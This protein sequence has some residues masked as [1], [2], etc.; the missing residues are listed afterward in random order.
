M[1]SE[2]PANHLLERIQKRLH[3]E[4]FYD[5]SSASKS[6]ASEV[7]QV[8]GQLSA[9]F[10]RQ[11]QSSNG[12][13]RSKQERSQV[14]VPQAPSPPMISMSEATLAMLQEKPND[15]QKY[16][17]Y[18]SY[19]SS[20]DYGHFDDDQAPQVCFLVI[21]ATTFFLDILAICLIN[22]CCFLLSSC[23]FFTLVVVKIELMNGGI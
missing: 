4:N 17:G 15:P 22:F 14:M 18:S 16:S 23:S 10:N 1:E 21:S 7:G 9:Y 11:D 5:G 12:I 19:K 6:M 13:D 3:N 8:L 20:Q 2:T